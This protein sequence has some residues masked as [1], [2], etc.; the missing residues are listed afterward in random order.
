MYIILKTAIFVT[1]WWVLGK[2]IQ[3]CNWDS[4][5]WILKHEIAFILSWSILLK[6][7]SH[8]FLFLDCSFRST[9]STILGQYRPTLPVSVRCNFLLL[10][11]TWTNV[12][13]TVVNGNVQSW[14]C[15]ISICITFR[16]SSFRTSQRALHTSFAI[17]PIVH[18]GMWSKYCTLRYESPGTYTYN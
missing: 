18:A 3:L 14:N 6:D 5:K 16:H 8:L 12:L 11:S 1:T 7:M 15:C 4:R 9:D 10:C 17:I 2:H 13:K